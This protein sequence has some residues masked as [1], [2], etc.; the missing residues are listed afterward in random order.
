M[1]GRDDLII[2]VLTER[3]RRGRRPGV[4]FAVG[5]GWWHREYAKGL[6]DVVL[7]PILQ[8]ALH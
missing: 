2:V 1:P 8:I 7:F 6:A 3:H 5:W 4:P